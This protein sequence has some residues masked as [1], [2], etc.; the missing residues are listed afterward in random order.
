AR[1]PDWA[2]FASIAAVEHGLPR[3][4][5]RIGETRIAA[6]GAATANALRTAGVRVDA[7]PDREE[8]EGLLELPAFHDMTGATVWIVR[9]RGGR[10]L[11]AETLRARG[12]DVAFV[13]VY[14]RR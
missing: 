8:S 11:L 3:V 13:E 10:G 2:I 14:E 9:G 1:A 12:A 6:I 4:R 7:V 5:S